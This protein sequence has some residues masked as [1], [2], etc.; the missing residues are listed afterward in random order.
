MLK[1]TLLLISA[2]TVMS[3]ALVAPSLPYMAEA[4]ANE[5]GIELKTKLVL[6]LPGLFIALGAPLAGSL[7]DR[8]SKKKLI[9]A[10]LLVFAIAGSAG[11]ILSNLNAILVSRALLGL[12]VAIS[13]T[14]VTA[15]VGDYFEGEERSRFI[16][17]QGAVMSFGGTVLVAL[18]GW[19][20]GL[21]WRYPFGVYGAGF[22]VALAVMI[23]IHEPPVAD[24]TAGPVASSNSW[25]RVSRT[26]WIVLATVCAGMIMFYVI[27]AQS[28][29]LLKQAGADSSLTTSLGLIVATLTS[30]L[31]AF[32]YGKLKQ[33]ATFNQLYALCFLLF[34]IG[35][36]SVYWLTSP[37]AMIAALAVSGLGAGLLIPNTTLCL[38]AQTD[39][40]N[41]G[42]TMG[43]N[44]SAIFLG[45]F[46]SPLAFQPLLANASLPTA[47]LESGLLALL[48][49][50]VYGWGA[51]HH[52][53]N[54]E[55]VLSR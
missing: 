22:L 38:L 42:S 5:P 33:R 20:A 15:L 39:A 51:V 12:S 36:V 14:G 7:L 23:V 37:G 49:A 11:L 24:R 47:F 52:Q 34:A 8:F 29:F 19:L 50:L 10:S 53:R 45:Q 2:M 1:I 55:K 26:Q 43:R 17:V 48:I 27:P 4:F 25:R 54:S 3:G 21:S 6:T 16:G 28:P 40:T 46:L 41:R 9:I 30:A 44:T 18:A 13:M 35:Y 32:F 31:A